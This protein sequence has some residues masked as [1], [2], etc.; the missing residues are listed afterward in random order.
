MIKSVYIFWGYGILLSIK[1][2][3]ATNEAKMKG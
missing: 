2:I 3:A 1:G